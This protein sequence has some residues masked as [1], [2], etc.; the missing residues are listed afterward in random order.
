[1][2]T[3]LKVTKKN[4]YGT[5]TIYPA[6]EQSKLFA[7]IAGTKT[8]KLHT[9]NLAKQLGYTFEVQTLTETL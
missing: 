4:V 6:C 5:I 7:Q 1:M 3:T 8:L 2:N 9:I